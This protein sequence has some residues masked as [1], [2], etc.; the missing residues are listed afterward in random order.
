VTMK[1]VELTGVVTLQLYSTQLQETSPFVSEPLPWNG[2]KEEHVAE[3]GDRILVDFGLL[4]HW[5]AMT[6][7]DDQRTAVAD[8][9]LMDGIADKNHDGLAVSQ[10]V[11]LDVN[12]PAYSE[13]DARGVFRS[14]TEVLP[15]LHARYW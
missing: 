4:N 1:I 2:Q 8:Q 6:R 3:V 7:A 5:I 12:E 15:H 13:L 11:L 14:G 10:V 9:Y